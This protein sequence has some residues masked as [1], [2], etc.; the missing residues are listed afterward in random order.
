M[1]TPSPA[2]QASAPNPKKYCPVV[3]VKEHA[4]PFLVPYYLTVAAVLGAITVG[5]AIVFV[6]LAIVTANCNALGW[7]E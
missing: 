5:F 6:L 1:S 2:A 4:K 3:W 7:V